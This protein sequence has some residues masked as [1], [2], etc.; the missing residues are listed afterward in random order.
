M[1]EAGG[2]PLKASKRPITVASFEALAIAGVCFTFMLELDLS[3]LG[4][5]ETA[6][7]LLLIVGIT[8]LRSNAARWIYSGI[9]V[10]A[11]LALAYG[12]AEGA[13]RWPD[14]DL[15]K[16]LFVATAPIE[17][18]LLWSASTSKWLKLHRDQEELHLAG[19]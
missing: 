7:L 11:A 19:Q 4:L 13:I 12:I 3:W 16:W 1:L 5:A 6:L 2:L 18:A 10:I 15:A 17:L 9:T 14:F 8:R